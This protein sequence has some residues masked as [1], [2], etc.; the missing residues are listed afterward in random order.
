MTKYSL[1][2]HDLLTIL[3]SSYKYYSSIIVYKHKL[4][5]SSYT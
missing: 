5:F 3:I 4:V 1:S 2:S